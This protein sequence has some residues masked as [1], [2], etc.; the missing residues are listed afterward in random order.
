MAS[1]FPKFDKKPVP[2]G[3]ERFTRKGEAF[4]RVTDA[5]GQKRTYPLTPDG[6]HLLLRRRCWYVAYTDAQGMRQVVKGFADREATEQLGRNLACQADR[7]RAGLLVIDTDKV[8]ASFASVLELFLDDLER[9]GRDEK[10]RAILGQRL[11]RLARECHWPTLASVRPQDMIAWLAA[12]K[13]QGLAAPTLNDYLRGVRSF[14]GWCI[15]KHYLDHDPLAGIAKADSRDKQRLRR[16]LARD[17]L[18]ALLASAPKRRLVYLTAM[19]TGLRR[20]EL[21]KLEWGDLVLD[22][23]L[24]HL[25]LRVAGTKARRGDLIPLDQE[26]AELLRAARPAGVRDS[27]RVFAAVPSIATYK[28]DLARAGIAYRDDQGRY[29][30]FHALRMSYNMLLAREGVAPRVA[31][32]LMR[33]HDIRLTMQVYTD[34]RLLDMQGAVDKLPPLL[35]ASAPAAEPGFRDS[36]TAGAT[37]KPEQKRKGL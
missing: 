6:Q 3:A 22:A 25:R 36:A 11:R 5:R 19:K 4:A 8:Q 18:M 14:I 35:P 21:R 20:K 23:E 31:Q 27:D 24:P 9:Q 12:Q 15:P 32:E 13:K 37:S 7:A 10:Y 29:A 34:P 17:Q 16:A 30:D 26:L 1:V 2:T 33:H 28:R